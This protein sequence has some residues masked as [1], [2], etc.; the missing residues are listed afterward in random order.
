MK[1][2]KQTLHKHNLLVSNSLRGVK[3]CNKWI[4]AAQI[5]QNK[6][7]WVLLPYDSLWDERLLTEKEPFEWRMT[8]CL[9]AL[10]RG[11]YQGAHSAFILWKMTR[12]RAAST[13]GIFISSFMSLTKRWLQLPCVF[14]ERL[15]TR[16]YTHPVHTR[17]CCSW[18]ITLI[19][20][21]NTLNTHD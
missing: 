11:V 21:S 15:A 12:R 5:N 13:G 16:I 6:Y 9:T 14:C 20:H 18:I 3:K 7:I 19:C 8:S 4:P 2:M 17:H 1:E 10:Q